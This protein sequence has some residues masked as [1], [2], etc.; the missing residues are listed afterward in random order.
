MLRSFLLILLLLLGAGPARATAPM[1]PHPS[2]PSIPPFD[3]DEGDRNHDD[4][5][6]GGDDES[7]E[8]HE[9]TG[10]D[11]KG[12]T[13]MP[14]AGRT[15]ARGGEDHDRGRTG[16]YDDEY[17]YYGRVQATAPEVVVGSR[18]LVGELALLEYLAPGM[19]VEVEG[20]VENGRIRVRELHILFPR[21][22]A[23]YEGPTPEGWARIWY[24]GG[25]PWRTQA[26]NPGPRA[27]LLACF[28]EDWLGLP[29]ELHPA[30][31]PPRPGLWLLEGLV[32]QGEVRWTR[33]TRLGSCDG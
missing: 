20:R 17:A 11:E 27:R 16:G 1:P 28:E 10:E 15:P 22:W 8:R 9:R 25:R 32:W 26:A 24:A 3:R 4:E 13:E 21:N 19:R 6:R 2:P 5:E 18:I 30:I 14:P 7:E 31:H 23:Y 29:E 33:Q 12:D